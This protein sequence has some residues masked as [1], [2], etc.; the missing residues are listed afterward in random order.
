MK[1]TVGVLGLQGDFALHQKSLEQ[2]KVNAPNIRKPEELDACDGLILPGGE[3]TTFIK[4]LKKTDL[5]KKI[6]QFAKER[7]VMGTWT[8]RN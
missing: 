3:T 6:Q 1:K 7:P 5:F 4:L 8:R 2:V